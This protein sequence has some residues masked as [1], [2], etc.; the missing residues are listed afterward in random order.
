[1]TIADGLRTT[2]SPLTFSIL[3]Q[4]VQD[5]ITIDDQAIISAMKLIW[6]RM[7]IIVEPSSATA[8]AAVAAEREQFAGCR[9]GIILSGGN[10]DL[11]NL[12]W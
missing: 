6:E 3:K 5:I 10:V 11:D 4:N 12:P 1:N 2:L 9:V 8:L 7:K